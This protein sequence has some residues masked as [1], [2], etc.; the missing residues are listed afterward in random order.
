MYC[1]IFFANIRYRS[2]F[3]IKNIVQKKT[4]EIASVT[5]SLAT[6]K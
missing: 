2:I 4:T 1:L 5:Q 3:K 6:R